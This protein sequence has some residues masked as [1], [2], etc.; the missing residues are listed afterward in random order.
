M[1][2]M[3]IGTIFLVG[4]WGI[5][6]KANIFKKVIALSIANS[7][8]ILLFIYYGSIS[9]ETA[10][11]EGT[12]KNMVDPL[13]QALMLTTIVVGICVIALSLVLVYRLYV[14]FKT[15][16]IRVIEKKARKLHE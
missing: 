13:P 12:L 4:L 16:D 5:M 15:L 7:G 9:G 14:E 2:W 10:P 11:I 3:L 6:N 1:T 8:I